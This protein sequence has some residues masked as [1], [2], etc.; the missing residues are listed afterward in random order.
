MQTEPVPPSSA[1]NPTHAQSLSPGEE[2]QTPEAPTASLQVAPRVHLTL[3][4]AGGAL[5]APKQEGK[6]DLQTEAEPGRL[7]QISP[8]ESPP[9]LSLEP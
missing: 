5:S 8:R 3:S 9:F 7:V 4:V 1:R 2:A 6:Q